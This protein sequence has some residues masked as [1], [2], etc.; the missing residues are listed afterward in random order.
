MVPAVDASGSFSGKTQPVDGFLHDWKMNFYKLV[1]FCQVVLVLPPPNS[2]VSVRTQPLPA[3]A[4]GIR[5]D[6]VGAV[7]V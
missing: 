6:S 2:S 7:R 3:G 1:F 5:L 4:A